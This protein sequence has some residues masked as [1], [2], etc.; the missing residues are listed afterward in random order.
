M[1]RKKPEKTLGLYLRVIFSVETAYN[2][3]KRPNNNKKQ[4][5]LRNRED[6]VSRVITL[7]DSITKKIIRHTKK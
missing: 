7:L 2:N 1:L 6:L 4:Q 3:D 5:I